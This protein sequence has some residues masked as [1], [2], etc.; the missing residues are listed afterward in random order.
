MQ[1]FIP[2]FRVPETPERFHRSTVSKFH[3]SLTTYGKPLPVAELGG[4][5]A[6]NRYSITR[7]AAKFGSVGHSCEI[8]NIFCIYSIYFRWI[9]KIE[10]TF[11]KLYGKPLNL[12]SISYWRFLTICSECTEA[13]CCQM[14]KT[15]RTNYL[16]SRT[17]EIIVF[18]CGSNMLPWE[19]TSNKQNRDGASLQDT[20]ETKSLSINRK[21]L[22]YEILIVCNLLRN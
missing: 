3:K 14:W 12:L 2:Q 21:C 19:C 8:W 17:Y 6:G 22:R 1:F 7:R 13:Y 18:T 15:S 10:L 16:I 11:C 20:S 5:I 4:K 9:H